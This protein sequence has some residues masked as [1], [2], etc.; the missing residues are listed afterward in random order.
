MELPEYDGALLLFKNARKDDIDKTLALSLELLQ[1]IKDEEF[2]KERLKHYF[3]HLIAQHYLK[4]G[5]V[6]HPLRVALTGLKD[7]PPPYDV[8]EVLGKKESIKRIKIA[9]KKLK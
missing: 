9:L 7:S 5:I 1:A 3:D 4:I 2:N 6:L 8:A